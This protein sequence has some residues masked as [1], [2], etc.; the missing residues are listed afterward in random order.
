[1]HCTA[2]PAAS[3]VKLTKRDGCPSGGGSPGSRRQRPTAWPRLPLASPPG[4]PSPVVHHDMN[5]RAAGSA[6]LPW[7]VR[8]TRSRP[9]VARGMTEGRIA[10]MSAPPDGYPPRSRAPITIVM[11]HRR[12]GVSH[13]RCDTRIARCDTRGKPRPVPSVSSGLLLSERLRS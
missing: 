6:S 10:T 4:R 8:V 11:S 9:P 12:R 7:L 13:A 5:A 3:F 1:V 2:S